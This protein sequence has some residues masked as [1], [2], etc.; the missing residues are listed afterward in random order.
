MEIYDEFPFRVYLSGR[1]RI[2]TNSGTE[3]T[4]ISLKAQGLLALLATEP[5]MTR[6]RR[7]LQDKL[8]SDSDSKHGSGSLRSEII[9][10]RN[11]FGQAQDVLVASKL[12]LGLDTARVV[13]GD[14]GSATKGEF[15][16]GIDVDDPEFEDWLMVMRSTQQNAGSQ[17]P[18]LNQLTPV[19]LGEGEILIAVKTDQEGPMR[20]HET[21]FADIVCKS[22]R[23]LFAFEARFGKADDASPGTLRLHIGAMD[24]GDQKL[25]IRV[26]VDRLA[27]G[28]STWAETAYGS[29]PKSATIMSPEHL[30]LSHR[31]TIA[32]IDLLARAKSTEGSP[33]SADALAGNA[34]NKM[35][36]MRR[37]QFAEA[38]QLLQD[39]YEQ[40]PRGLYQAW[41]AQLSV[42]RFVEAGLD[43]REAHDMAD[44]CC[45]HA[46]AYEPMNSN[47]LAAVANARLVFQQDGA[48]A[49]EL[50]MLS[51]K[52]N[53]ANPFAWTSWTNS[54]LYTGEPEKAVAAAKTGQTLAKDGKFRFWADFYVALTSLATGQHESAI[55]FSERARALNPAFRPPLRYLVGLFTSGGDAEKARQ[56]IK[57][58]ERI[59][60]EFSV[61]RM[62]EDDKYPVSMMRQNG[63][64]DPARLRD[65]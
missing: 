20:Q 46:M 59:E 1:F 17:A 52:M 39:A 35:F 40:E 61:D 45:A 48:A 32:L 21:A 29:Y 7:W 50:S 9:K 58:L 13:L 12:T 24:V 65:I 10:I 3:V 15:L 37:E 31:T 55:K 38:D 5:K 4:P 18:S 16:E 51:V 47:V 23:E 22:I 60:P 33:L 25:G 49:R 36:T 11:A 53:P 42:I 56:T 28:A 54:L 63:L 43:A 19:A 34:L 64:I 41:R 26:A 30:G 57:R 6:H 8:W 14:A 27:S 62:I 44:E 2:E